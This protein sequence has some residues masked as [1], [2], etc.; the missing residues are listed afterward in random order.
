MGFL[1]DLVGSLFDTVF[2]FGR[3]DR[4]LRRVVEHGELV[5]ATVYAIKHVDRSDS[6]SQWSYGLD[7]QTSAGPYRT[8]VRQHLLHRPELLT[9]GCT[10]KVR[11]LK[12]RVAIDW[13]RT[14]ADH[15]IDLE[16]SI[17]PTRMSGGPLEPGIRDTNVDRR[18]LERGT[19]AQATVVAE[20]PVEVLGMAT[21]NVTLELDVP[22]GPGATRRVTVKRAL[23]PPYAR[24]RLVTGAVL[25]VAIHPNKP[26]KV[27]IDWETFGS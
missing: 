21:Q 23:V 3:G 12:G 7:V 22:D 14:L 4:T 15:G 1:D 2:S 9:L 20:T 10:V 18:A 5:P 17:L 11:H 16:E 25:P 6:P 26:D 27:T 13:T 8:T 24:A 19:P